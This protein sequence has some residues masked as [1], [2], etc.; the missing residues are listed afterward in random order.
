MNKQLIEDKARYKEQKMP[1][2]QK[3]YR[4]LQEKSILRP[5]YKILF[6]VC[7]KMYMIE[8]SEHTQIGGGLYLGHARLITINPSAVIGK[9]CNIH[10]GVTIGQENRGKRKGCPTI[11]NNVWIGINSTIVGKV[12]IGDDVLI[13]PNSYVNCDVPSHSVCFGNPIIIK[14]KENATE[15]YINNTI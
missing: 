7:K 3:Y 4:K 9:N 10:K 8:M 13:A 11:G 5:I 2:F 15:Q 1:L 6:M 12:N 14:P